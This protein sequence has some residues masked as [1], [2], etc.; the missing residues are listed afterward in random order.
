MERTFLMIKPDGVQRK[1]VGE[2]IT[3]LEKKGLKLV[4]GKFMTVSKEKA[5]THYGEHADKPFYEGLVSFITSAP[6]FAMVVE[7]ENVVE[8]TRNMIGK[9]NPTEAAPGTIRGDLGLTVGRNVIHGSDSV[10]SAKREI[11]LWFEPNELSVY[12]ANDE[13]WLYEN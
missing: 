3:R 9:T 8:V 12:T 11:S 5:E 6:V 10:E 13:E 7:G 2:I 4:G 1:L